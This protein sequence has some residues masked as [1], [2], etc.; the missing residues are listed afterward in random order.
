MEGREEEFQT[1]RRPPAA[2]LRRGS[3]AHPNRP[4]SGLCVDQ[5]ICKIL[6]AG[7]GGPSPDLSQY[8]VPDPSSPLTHPPPCDP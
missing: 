5:P 3:P 6:A 2:Q 4:T 1:L 8:P 7:E